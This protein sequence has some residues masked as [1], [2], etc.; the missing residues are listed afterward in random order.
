MDQAL[1]MERVCVMKGTMQKGPLSP[2]LFSSGVLC[3]ALAGCPMALC[4][5]DVEI[6]VP[7]GWGQKF[8]DP[9]SALRQAGEALRDP[10]HAFDGRKK[11][12]GE[13]VIKELSRDE[14]KQK[15]GDLGK[16]I[17]STKKIIES[18]DRMIADAETKIGE[19]KKAMDQADLDFEK[20]NKEFEK[21]HAIYES[22][23]TDLVAMG[24]AKRA[25]KED[26]VDPEY[27]DTGKGKWQDKQ[28]ALA[29][30]NGL[31]DKWKSLSKEKDDLDLKIAEHRKKKE[32]AKLDITAKEDEME[33]LRKD[34]QGVEP[35][36][37][38]PQ[39]G[40]PRID[41]VYVPPVH[42][43]KKEPEGWGDKVQGKIQEFMDWLNSE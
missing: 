39:P 6:E 33:K 15:Y 29:K 20:A 38:K 42:V 43:P 31:L 27:Y 1:G 14:M 40:N 8:S 3:L 2:L 37:Y 13:V 35:L 18:L 11:T 26:T 36:P 12:E 34:M 24:K 23:I 7:P 17:V 9:N 4:G 19:V 5:D 21:L 10:E 30:A 28:D 22:Y 41:E 32:E 16:E 25:E